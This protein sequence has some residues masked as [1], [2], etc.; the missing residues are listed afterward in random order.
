MKFY[1]KEWSESLFSLMTD[2]GH[3]LGYFSSVDEAMEACEAWYRANGDELQFDIA[4]QS[5]RSNSSPVAVV[6]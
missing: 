3:M 2:A 4:I 5:Y 6:Y 1:I